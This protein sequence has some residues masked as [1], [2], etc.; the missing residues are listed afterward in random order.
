M[1]VFALSRIQVEIEVAQELVRL[2]VLDVVHGDVLVPHDSVR[3]LREFEIQ[4]LLID[5]QQA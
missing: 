1:T 4:Q 2:R 5:I 3:D